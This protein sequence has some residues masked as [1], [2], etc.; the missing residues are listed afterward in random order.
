MSKINSDIEVTIASSGTVSTPADLDGLALVGI[1]M[2]ATF[3]GTALTFSIDNG[4]GVFNV[5]A[6]GAGA[7]VSKTVAASKFINLP[8]SDFAGINKIKLISGTT[9]TGERVIRLVVR[10]IT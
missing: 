7:D 2:P 1:H 8:P 4:E 10:D 5:M 9:E 6:D 3:T